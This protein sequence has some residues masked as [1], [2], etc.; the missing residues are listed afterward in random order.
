LFGY[1]REELIG[2]TLQ[3]LIPVYVS[4]QQPNTSGSSPEGFDSADELIGLRKD[5]TEFPLE[6]GLNQI[7]SPNGN[8]VLASII[9]VTERKIQ[10]ANRL[11]SD[12]L[13]NM[14]HEL[15]T[16]LNAVLG[17]SELLIDKKVG[18]LNAKQLEYLNDIHASGSHL[19][20]LIN[21]VLDIAKIEAGKADL[22]IETFN[23][24]DV[25]TEV[26]QT[27]RP[28]A[29]KKLI[30]I[31]QT[32]APEIR[33]VSID[34]NK[35]RQILYNL[36]SNA[37]KFSNHVAVVNVETLAGNR[38]TFILKVRDSG[39]GIAAYNLKK[40]FVPFVQLDSGLARQHQGSGLGLSV[41]KTIVALHEGEISV[42]ST[43]GK[44][45]TFIVKLPIIFH[46]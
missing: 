40:L 16:P 5:G 44:G 30:E 25:I 38:N 35:L 42:E 18:D 37:I 36:L 26:I 9:D 11:K 19:L 6:L 45:S 39:I 1:E 7:D 32:L 12:F 24:G 34:K 43:L 4:I 15:R 20:R 8:Q 46:N 14:S 41:T 31:T 2:E 28:I 17:F 23:L 3:K 10:E 13:A 33:L 27:L 29:E 21:N 22:V